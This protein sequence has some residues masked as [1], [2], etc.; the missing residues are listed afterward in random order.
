VEVVGLVEQ[1]QVVVA[2]VDIV[3]QQDFLLL[4]VLLILL[5][6]VLAEQ[7]D[8]EQLHLKPQGSAEMIQFLVL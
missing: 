7:V 2:Q 3:P 4:P 6:L 5:L 8:M 1:D